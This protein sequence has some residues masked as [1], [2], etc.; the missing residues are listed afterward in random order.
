MI[1]APVTPVNVGGTRRFTRLADGLGGTANE[2]NFAA[3]A[4]SLTH[5]SRFTLPSDD[6][7]PGQRVAAIEC[8]CQNLAE[9]NAPPD[10]FS[11]FGIK[12]CTDI[13]R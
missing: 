6:V 9:N 13:G 2:A 11:E 1:W 3:G 10:T 12:G 4:F 8:I 5:P 7:V